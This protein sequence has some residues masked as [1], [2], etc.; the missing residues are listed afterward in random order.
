[1]QT[2]IGIQIKGVEDHFVQLKISN[3]TLLTFSDFSSKENVKPL[4]YIL[5]TNERSISGPLTS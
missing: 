3:I 4:S 1:M 5:K 2:K